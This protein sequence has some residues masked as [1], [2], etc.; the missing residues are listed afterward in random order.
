[1]SEKIGG[2]KG[3]ELDDEFIE[4]ERVSDI[5]RFMYTFFIVIKL[6]TMALGKCSSFEDDFCK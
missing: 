4:M 6:N 3:T 5:F 2:A 1:M